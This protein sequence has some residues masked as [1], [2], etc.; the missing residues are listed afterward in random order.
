MHA[1]FKI[2]IH[3]ETKLY[4]VLLRTP[5]EYIKTEDANLLTNFA[6]FD[7]NTIYTSR[8][9]IDYVRQSVL[10]DSVNKSYKIKESISPIVRRFL[11]VPDSDKIFNGIDYLCEFVYDDKSKWLPIKLPEYFKN[12]DFTIDTTNKYYKKVYYPKLNKVGKCA[13]IYHS[14]ENHYTLIMQSSLVNGSSPLMTEIKEMINSLKII[15]K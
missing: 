3:K 5:D 4:N 8:S 10:Q 12:F 14:Y 9:N 13:F 11:K 2:N 1:Y 6:F 15:K 7:S